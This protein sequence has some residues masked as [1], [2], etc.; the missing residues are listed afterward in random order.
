MI[1]IRFERPHD[2]NAIRR[3]NELAFDGNVEADLIDALREA[4]VDTISLVAVDGVDI[5]G[6]ILFSPVA[7]QSERS[8]FTALALGPM[9]VIPGHQRKGIGTQLVHAGLRECKKRGHSIVFVLGHREYYPR[10]GFLSS[11]PLGFR[12]EK[13]VP[14]EYFMVVELEEGAL[15]GKDGVVKYHPAF[16]EE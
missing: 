12:W 8:S 2:K 3:V 4:D 15:E 13:D 6:H 1:E 9:A 11:R 7:V 10:F 14:E 16:D 5:I